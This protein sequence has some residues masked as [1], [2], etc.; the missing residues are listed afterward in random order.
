MEHSYRH[1]PSFTSCLLSRDPQKPLQAPQDCTKEP[2]WLLI[3]EKFLGLRSINL[4]P[5]NSNS[6]NL[7]ENRAVFPL[8]NVEKRIFYVV[9]FFFSSIIDYRWQNNIF[10]SS[11]STL[12]EISFANYSQ[13]SLKH[14]FTINIWRKVIL[15]QYGATEPWVIMEMFYMSY[16]CAVQYESL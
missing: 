7:S 11:E 6:E 12:P 10:F 1:T 5:T 4:D 14:S 9:L 16:T 13:A 2:N 3:L 15:D 8:Y